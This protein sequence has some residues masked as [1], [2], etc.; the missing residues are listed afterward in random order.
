MESYDT[1]QT[2]KV[3][4]THKVKKYIFL[5][6]TKRLVKDSDFTYRNNHS[7]M[8]FKIGILENSAKLSR[9]TCL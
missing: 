2:H 6:E 8:F 5:G 9:E 4:E 3:K 1:T 7:Q